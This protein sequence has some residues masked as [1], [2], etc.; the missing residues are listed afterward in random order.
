MNEAQTALTADRPTGHLHLGHYVGSLKNRLVLQ[1]KHKCLIMIADVQ[2][3]SDNFDNPQKVKENI[4]E[5]CKDYL[6]VGLNPD[7]CTIFVQSRV[8]ELSELTMYYLNLV[9]LARLER[10]PTVK[11]ELK[12]KDWEDSIP[13]GFLCYPISQAAD[14]TAFK[15]TLIPVGEDQLPMIELS[16]EIVRRFNR[17]YNS[18]VLVESEAVLSDT[19]RLIGID[20]K[21][22]AS[23]S[24]NNAIFLSDSEKN[25]KEKINNMYTDPNHIKIT[26]PGTV[27]GNVVFAYLDAFFEDKQELVS[28]KKQ[29]TKGG[30]GDSVLKSLLNDVLQALLKPI[31]EKRES[32]LDDDIEKILIDG[33]RAARNVS[34]NTLR[35]VKEA[36]GL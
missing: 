1:G 21:S 20:G 35:E 16:N 10:N 3:L 15:A 26:D 12:Q 2:A 5:V 18:D 11:A 36:I 8:P 29:Y 19:K 23:K 22:K 31:R 33:S 4:K 13:M 32:I 27:E 25:I 17:L 9:T 28:L 7:K 6:A 34:Q 30:L 24:L 14:I